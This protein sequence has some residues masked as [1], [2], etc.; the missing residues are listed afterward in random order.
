M[1]Q[2]GVFVTISES[3]AIKVGTRTCSVLIVT[4]APE[5]IPIM[6]PVC[7]TDNL[8]V[9]VVPFFNCAKSVTIALGPI[10]GPVTC[11]PGRIVSVPG[12]INCV[13]FLV[14]NTPVIV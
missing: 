11:D 4:V 3:P 12:R 13:E 10:F 8:T 5:P 2:I 7:A 1:V 6:V 14:P 9:V